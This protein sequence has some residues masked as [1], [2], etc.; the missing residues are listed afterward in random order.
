M[1]YDAVV[2]DYDGVVMEPTPLP[3]LQDA[4][5]AA[6]SR[7]GVDPADD[8]VRDLAI[9]VD[10]DTLLETCDHYDLDPE[11]FW[12][13]R[14]TAVSDHQAALLER[15]GKGLYDDYDA[16]HDIALP[17]GIVSSNQ[18]A[19]LDHHLDHVAITDAFSAV[20]G[21]ELSLESVLKKKPHP[22]YLEAAMSDLESSDPLFVGDS[23]SDV[24]AARNAGV[25]SAYIHREHNG[26][27]DVAPTH[28]ITSLYDLPDIIA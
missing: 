15:G 20:Y 2:F 27:A 18:Q 11:T 23:T 3:V 13:A 6:F 28:E 4:V 26:P 5:R 9:H 17:M 25:D 14:D 21:R 1:P 24:V 10:Y 12:Y 22:H 7:V 8:H 19:T 16:I